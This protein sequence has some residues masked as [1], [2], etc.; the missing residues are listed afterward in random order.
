MYIEVNNT[1]LFYQESGQ[2]R[3][4]L[5]LH[6]NGED[7]H[8]FDEI[9]PF[10]AAHFHIYAIDSRNHGQSA[11][12]EDYS[13]QSMADDIAAFIHTLSLPCPHLLGF[14]DGA[15]IALLLALKEPALLSHLALLGVNLSPQDFKEEI[16]QEIAEEYAATH[17]P[18]LALMLNEPQI[19][20]ASLCHIKNPCFVIAGEHDIYKP[21][22]FSDIAA[23]LPNSQLQIMARH[24]H[25]SYIVDSSLL[26][27]ALLDFFAS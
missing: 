9:A 3:P 5:L 8:I 6:G 26:A 19:E 21:Q 24:D 2:G 23:A 12:Q 18:L 7:H 14:S 1:R 15:I 25:S 11:K 27:G 10:L 4:L 16:Y 13:Y 22:L 20:L 17:D